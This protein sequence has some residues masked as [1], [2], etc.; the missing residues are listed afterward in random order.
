M[1]WR[2]RPPLLQELRQ[3]LLEL[4]TLDKAQPP[5]GLW[6]NVSSPT[7]IHLSFSLLCFSYSPFLFLCYWSLKHCLLFRQ[8]KLPVVAMPKYSSLRPKRSQKES[9]EEVNSQREGK[10]FNA[11]RFPSEV[12]QKL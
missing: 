5:P 8:N 3:W 12:L 7:P 6:E 2:R 1:D 9:K 10:N 4:V 11:M